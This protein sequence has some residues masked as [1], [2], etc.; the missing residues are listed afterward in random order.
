MAP[1]IFANDSK[2][3]YSDEFVGGFEFEAAQAL[4]LGVRY[5][6]RNTPTVLEDYAQASPVMYELEFPGLAT[7]ST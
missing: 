5:I 1:A 2:S 7:S 3:T 4:N 6:H